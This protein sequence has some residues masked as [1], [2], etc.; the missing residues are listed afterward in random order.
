MR[1][2][3]G[4]APDR[5]RTELDPTWCVEHQWVCTHVAI[6]Q[7]FR[8]AFS[9]QRKSY[10]NV[11]GDGEGGIGFERVGVGVK[12]KGNCSVATGG[13]C[14]GVGDVLL[15]QEGEQEGGCPA[16]AEDEEVDGGDVVLWGDLEVAH[17]FFWSSKV[18]DE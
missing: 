13:A 11:G 6:D 1:V 10:Q 8:L 14:G 18:Y 3:G 15:V 12:S 5:R 9:F 4:G 7:L 16:G 17:G 2:P